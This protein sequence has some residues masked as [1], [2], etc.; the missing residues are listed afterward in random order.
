MVP[1][2]IGFVARRECR[3]MLGNRRLLIILL[4]I[5]FLYIS[6]F[7]V[8]Y[9]RHVI[10]HIP[11]VVYDMNQTGLSREMVQAF[12]DSQKFDLL[13]YVD[14]EAQ[15]NRALADRRA[16][17]ALVIPPD[18]ARAVKSGRQGRLLVVVNGTNMLYSNAVMTAASEIAGTLSAGVSVTAL[19]SRGLLPGQALDAA[20][21]LNLR[22]RI[23]Y[24][25]AFNY[26]NFL[27]LGLVCTVMQQ[28]A[29]LY[30]AVAV[31]REKE[32][33][34]LEELRR[35]GISAPAVVLGKLLPYLLANLLTLNGV[36]L[37]VFTWFQVPFRGSIWVLGLLELLFLTGIHALGIFLSTVCRSE[38]EATQLAMLVAVPS[39]LFSGYTWPLPAMPPLARAVSSLLPLT[40]FASDVRDI[41]L[42]GV[43]LP[44]LARDLAVLAG[45]A[46]VLL[47]LSVYFF[48]RQYR[49]APPA[50]QAA[51]LPVREAGR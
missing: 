42:M 15:L 25:P 21:P 37:L 18:F 41:A 5:P 23:W 36:L 47:P 8:L 49:F 29:L 34:T 4:G 22:L 46:A 27:L 20:A 12:Q 9:S 32:Q 17:A 39:F 11:T 50:G 30:V 33:G 1:G 43:S 16:V 31:S 40:Y 45:L 51:A 3:Y 26:L 10:T 7:G 13:G 2:Q 6:L 48:H 19:E 44:V 24:N 35:A 14:D 38:L 28:I